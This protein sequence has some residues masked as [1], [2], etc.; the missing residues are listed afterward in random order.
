MLFD[1]V[2]ILDCGFVGATLT[3]KNARAHFIVTF[4]PIEPRSSE[5]EEKM[6]ILM[7]LGFALV[8]GSVG[9]VWVSISRAVAGY[10][11]IDYPFVFPVILMVIGTFL[12]VVG[13]G[14]LCAKRGIRW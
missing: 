11:T 7:G 10:T 2:G 12:A 9:L 1:M 14:R 6:V 3:I 4:V 13:V 8:L 5:Q